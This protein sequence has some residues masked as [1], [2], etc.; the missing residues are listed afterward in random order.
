VS[1]TGTAGSCQDG[2]AL[3]GAGGVTVSPDGRSVYVASFS[4]PATTGDAVAIFD[5]DTSGSATH[6]ALAQKT[7]VP[8]GCVSETGTTGFCQD[9]VALDGAFAVAVSPDGRS[10]YVASLSSSAVAIL[11]RDTSG[12]ASTGALTQKPSLAGCISSGGTGGLCQSGDGLA[13]ARGVA[14]T[15]DGKSV[16]I[17]AAQSDAL[18]IL[19][20]DDGG[21]ATHGELTQ[22][23]G[24]VPCISETGAG[25]C[26]DGVALDGA[27]GIAASP[28]GTSVYLASSASNAIAIFDREPLPA[29]DTAAPETTITGAPKPKVK[30]KKKKSKATFSFTS[31]EAGSTFECS[32]DNRPFGAC[33]SPAQMKVRKGNHTFS[34]RATDAAGNVDTTPASRAW[35]VKKK[36]KKKK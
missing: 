17:A 18:A 36:K 32:L 23:A 5:R 20:R 15:A 27:A 9:G 34:V 1:E 30:T 4:N 3:D 28:D 2:L 19:D 22:E 13:G 10:V 7:P 14:V 26:D 6:G 12:G 8:A 29:G 25:G 11:D 16:Y 24:A 21:G 31:S 35:K 33:T